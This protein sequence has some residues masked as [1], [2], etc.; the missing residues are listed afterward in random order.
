M[1]YLEYIEYFI[2]NESNSVKAFTLFV[3]FSV[4]ISIGS[5]VQ[6][7]LYRIPRDIGLV[8]PPSK[9]PN[10]F[11]YLKWY[12][13]V[14]IIGWLCQAGKCIQC[15]NKI[16]IRY[17]L[18]EILFGVIAVLLFVFLVIEHHS[19]SLYF[20]TLFLFSWMYMFALIDA[21]HG[22]LPDA[23]TLIPLAVCFVIDLLSI[24]EGNEQLKT[25][26]VLVP[27]L[28]IIFIPGIFKRSFIKLIGISIGYS[29]EERIQSYFKWNT[30]KLIT[31]Y[32]LIVSSFILFIFLIYQ[33]QFPSKVIDSMLAFL[34]VWALLS[35]VGWLA[36]KIAKK[37]ALGEG[38]IKCLACIG[39][40]FGLYDVLFVLIVMSMLSAIVGIALYFIKGKTMMRLG[41]YI[42]IAVLIIHALNIWFPLLVDLKI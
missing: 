22:I 17:L 8:F 30:E 20:F 6:A 18:A 31:P 25:I 29:Y 42:A 21:E 1:T 28:F 2:D 3:V 34:F 19:Y 11:N 12:Q 35:F 27:F 16:A 36:G 7:C 14:P 37:D 33:I 26:E 39:Y 32:N 41:P 15:K 23:L 38:D 24:S 10:C 9:C 4:G 13:N 5:F 40:F